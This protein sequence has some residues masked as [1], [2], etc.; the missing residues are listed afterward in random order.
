MLF[1]GCFHHA[2]FCTNVSSSIL[3]RMIDTRKDVTTYGNAT[4]SAYKER[5]SS[6][7]ADFLYAINYGLFHIRGI[8]NI[9][10]SH[11]LSKATQP[12]PKNLVLC[13]A[14]L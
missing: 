10:F 3:P 13:N 9:L 7:H 11:L 2:K 6:L 5:Q 12:S 8:Q 14:T 1:E 4:D